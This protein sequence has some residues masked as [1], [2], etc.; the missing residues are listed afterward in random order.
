[1]AEI[2]GLGLTHYSGLRFTDP[3]MSIFLRRTLEGSGVPAEMKDPQNWPAPMRR[4]WSDDQ[5][6]AEAAIHRKRNLEAFARI[7]DELARFDPDFVVMWGDDQYENF[8]ED[9]VPPFCVYILDEFRSTPFA[10]DPRQPEAA[11]P[12][13]EGPDTT[14]VHRGHPA[15]ATHLVEG[16]SARG[17]D[18]PYAY[19]LRHHRGLAHAFIN[20]LMFLDYDRTGFDYPLVPFHVNCYGGD[21]IRTQGGHLSPGND[22][23]RRDPPAPSARACFDLGREIARVLSESPWRVA[24]MASSSWSHAFLTAK[25]HW[26]YPDH[27][28]DRDRLAEL[29]AGD[30]AGWRDLDGAAIE[31]AGQHEFRNWICLAGAMSEIGAKV[32]IVDYIESYVMNSN[33]CFA[34]MRP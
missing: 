19:R 23:D 2:L 21:L 18:V 28:S 7:N 4:E 3:D 6:A 32:E 13:G 26:I 25:N 5:G 16:L 20:T 8:I 22:G 14:F 11:N 17:T 24:L 12:W 33:K 30:Y 34:V 1:M 27:A 31:A 9:V 15:G 10:H 29:R